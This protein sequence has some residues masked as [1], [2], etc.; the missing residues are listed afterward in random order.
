MR[1]LQYKKFK[2]LLHIFRRRKNRDETLK[3]DKNR[4]GKNKR[5]GSLAASAGG[6]NFFSERG[7]AHQAA[8]RGSRR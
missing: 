6:K 4:K 3:R 2:T 7:N 5:K 8:D 1:V